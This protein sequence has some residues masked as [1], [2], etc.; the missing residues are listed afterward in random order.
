[1]PL[2]KPYCSLLDVQRETKSSG[3]E[4]DELYEE[5]ITRASRWI[6]SQ[7]QRDFWFHDHSSIDYLVPRGRVLGDLALLPF[8][9]ITL[10]AVWVFSDKLAG[11][12]D[13][14]LLAIDEYYYEAGEP[15]I[16]C[17]SDQFGDYPFKGFFI[18]RGTFGYPLAET[19][20][21][22]TPPPTIP[23]EIRRAACLVASA[24]SDELHKE[25]TGLD[26]SR[27]EV[28]DTKI[29]AEARTLIKKWVEL[30]NFSF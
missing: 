13:N 1:M 4:N 7:C 28:L 16:S 24:W 25:E 27:M 6:D 22:T 26:G 3:S 11:K 2:E 9:I 29:P 19:D 18:V 10:D 8:P 21:E 23:A 17:E 5:C 14:D 15:S 20:P 30:I 12:T